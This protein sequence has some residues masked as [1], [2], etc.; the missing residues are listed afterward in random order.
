MEA[1]H[2]CTCTR[3]MLSTRV[4]VPD[5]A[6][7]CG[8]RRILFESLQVYAWDSSCPVHPSHTNLNCEVDSASRTR[9]NSGIALGTLT[10]GPGAGSR[11]PIVQTFRFW[12]AWDY[13]WTFVDW[14]SSWFWLIL[15]LSRP[16][17]NDL[18]PASFLQ[19]E[20]YI[21]VLRKSI[22]MWATDNEDNHKWDLADQS[23]R[24][25]RAMLTS[26]WLLFGSVF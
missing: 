9:N 16:T 6:E 1:S 14:K 26:I 8:T 7:I 20:G 13:L 3:S 18:A 22:K 24:A 2:V 19:D 10:Q 11:R 15:S 25:A 21:K 12:L 17:Q 4:R 5:G 23:N